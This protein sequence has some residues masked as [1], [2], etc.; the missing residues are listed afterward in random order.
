MNKSILSMLCVLSVFACTSLFASTSL[1]DT[2]LKCHPIKR[3]KCHTGGC[4]SKKISSRDLPLVISHPGIY[5]LERDTQFTP[6]ADGQVAIIVA[7]NDV[8][9]NLCGKRLF[10]DPSVTT[11]GNIGIQV[12]QNYDNVT[13]RNG[14]VSGFGLWGIQVQPGNTHININHIIAEGN[15]ANGFASPTAA[16]RFSGGIQVGTDTA[17]FTPLPI[18]VNT[19][20]NYCQWITIDSCSI[21]GNI[22]PTGFVRGLQGAGVKELTLQNSHFDSQIGLNESAGAQLFAFNNVVVT[23]CTF[24]NNGSTSPVPPPPAPS[25]FSG[26]TG[27]GL[28]CNGFGSNLIV[29][30]CT[31]NGNNA[32]ARAN[33]FSIQ[34]GIAI[35]GV[36]V[37][38]GLYSVGAVSNVTIDQC[39]ANNTTIFSPNSVNTTVG[40]YFFSN[41][42][43]PNL[44]GNVPNLLENVVVTNC[45]ANNLVNNSTAVTNQAGVWGFAV[46]EVVNGARIESCTARN[47]LCPSGTN[48]PC[49]GFFVGSAGATTAT[50]TGFA[51]TDVVLNNCVAS[52]GV[53]TNNVAGF[54]VLDFSTSS[55]VTPVAVPPKGVIIEN[56]I[57]EDNHLATV[58]AVSAEAAGILLSGAPQTKVIN[59]I[60]RDNQYGIRL[61]ASPFSTAASPTTRCIIERN[62][63]TDNTIAGFSD[64]AGATGFNVYKLNE[65]ANNNGVNYDAGVVASGAPIRTWALPARPATTDNNG[66]IDPLDNISITP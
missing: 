21:T 35:G 52:G 57:S 24:D 27:R 64:A 15:G 49:A 41:D 5:T 9:I 8:E 45:E 33:G 34:T 10:Q 3:H 63:A 47:Y 1:A 7:S 22:S 20:L 29:E 26:S 65:A 38:A 25:T 32:Q 11:L 53:G 55:G 6:K 17:T 39:T 56:C 46:S 13:I 2:D 12:S 54:L 51:P 42:M 62:L 61:D 60:V 16:P 66:I 58:H 44:P 36:P 43:S 31:F 50:L 37:S 40:F 18:T 30:R 59:C 19:T 14:V 23:D 48:S 28:F 4:E